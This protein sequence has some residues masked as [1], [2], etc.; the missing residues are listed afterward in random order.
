MK[1]SIIATSLA[2][3]ASSASASPLIA[4]RAAAPAPAQ[5]FTFSL[6]NDMTGANAAASVPING[7]AFVLKDLFPWATNLIKD[8]KLIAT[9]AQNINPGVQ[10]VFCIFSGNGRVIKI[11]DKIT[12]ADLDGVQGKA[13]Q[14]DVSLFTIQCEK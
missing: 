8:G 7:G 3:L 11:N 5:Q 2:L 4:A 13:V 10:N 14:T 1:A 6:T 9:S 12:F